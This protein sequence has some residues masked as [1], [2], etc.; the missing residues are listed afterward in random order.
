[1]DLAN[2]TD[3]GVA[4]RRKSINKTTTKYTEKGNPSSVLVHVQYIT[5][6]SISLRRRKPKMTSICLSSP[7]KQTYYSY[8]FSALLLPQR[9]RGSSHLHNYCSDFC[10]SPLS[11]QKHNLTSYLFSLLCSNLFPSIFPQL[12]KVLKILIY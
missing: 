1:M 4:N 6:S 11:L 7:D 5:F 10:L 3:Y 2:T 12:I 8:T 9:M